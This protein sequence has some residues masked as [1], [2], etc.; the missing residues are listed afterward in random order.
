M[1]FE[2][3]LV[4]FSFS[5]N[6]AEMYSTNVQLN[7]EILTNYNKIIRNKFIEISNSL[8][9]LS[10]DSFVRKGD[11]KREDKEAIIIKL[12]K[13][14]VKFDIRDASSSGLG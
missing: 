6:S 7:L 8:S 3:Y 2:N 11:S 5:L 9:S 4:K 14:C 12:K 10:E 13:I 1:I